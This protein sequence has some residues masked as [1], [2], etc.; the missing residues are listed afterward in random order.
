MIHWTGNE[1]WEMLFGVIHEKA[2]DL[3]TEECQAIADALN[4]TV[5]ECLEAAAYRI[6][7][8]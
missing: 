8:K 6:G 7:E 3:S 1:V 4:K 2:L 5:A